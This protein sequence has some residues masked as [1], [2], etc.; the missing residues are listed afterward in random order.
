MRVLD[1][2]GR[3]VRLGDPAT[4]SACVFPCSWIPGSRASEPLRRAVL[5]TVGPRTSTARGARCATIRRQGGTRG[6][7]W[8]LGAAL[9]IRP[10]GQIAYRHASG[11]ASD[12]PRVEEILAALRAA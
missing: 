9:V 6:D 2:K 5:S 1:Q 8:Q 3:E 12:H 10:S 11:E 7:P 4:R